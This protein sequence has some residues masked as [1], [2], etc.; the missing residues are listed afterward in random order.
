VVGALILIK[1]GAAS[2][3]SRLEGFEVA[4]TAAGLGMF[5]ALSIIASSPLLGSTK[6]FSVPDEVALRIR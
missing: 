1:Q 5:V 3:R 6:K 4:G 2:V